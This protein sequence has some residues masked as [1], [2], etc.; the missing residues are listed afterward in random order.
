MSFKFTDSR[1]WLKGIGCAYLRDPATGDV[2]YYS[3]KF[4]TGQVTPSADAGEI[5]AGAGNTLA[6]MLATNARV[7]V[8]FT[9]QD[10]DLFVKGASA[11]ATIESGAPVPVCEVVDATGA[12]IAITKS[13]GTPVAPLGY[14]KIIC[15]VQEVGAASLVANDGTAYAIDAD[16]GVISGFN[17]VAGTQYKVTYFVSRANAQLATLTGDMNGRVLHFTSEH[18]IYVNVDPNNKSGTYWGKLYTV[19]PLLKLTTDG[20]A[21]EGD[22]TANTTTG[23][24]GQALMYDDEVVVDDCGECGSSASPLAYY[25]VVPCDSTANISGLVVV[26]GVISVPVSTTYNINDFRLLVGK[27]LVAPDPAKMTYSLGDGAPA[28][29]SVSGS[30]L[31]TGSTAGDTEI[32]GTYTDAG[33]TITCVA[34]LSVIGG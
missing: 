3:N 10:F 19:V 9:A 8:N 29:T 31:T 15:Y 7:A 16:S 17:A 11:G 4:S 28:G 13:A 23:I 27:S 14:S 20:A 5:S 6:T 25:I 26:G 22:Q 1:L 21:I 24:V 30:V 2:V 33:T 32:T 34:N 12:E 18:D